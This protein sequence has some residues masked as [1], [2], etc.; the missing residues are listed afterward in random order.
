MSD[1]HC[2]A[3]LIVVPVTDADPEEAD[4]LARSLA[5]RR[6][7]RIYG[8]SHGAAR[9]WGLAVSRALG[10]EL[11]TLERVQEDPLL[12]WVPAIADLHRGETVVVLTDRPTPWHGAGSGTIEL[13]VD[14][15]GV[16]LR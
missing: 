10:V 3:T 4:A 9:G 8:S 12:S 1:L 14:A 2:A 6:V 13:S 5:S 7:A 11:V 16:V 15:D